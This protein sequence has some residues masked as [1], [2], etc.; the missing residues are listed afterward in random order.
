MTPGIK[1]EPRPLTPKNFLSAIWQANSYYSNYRWLVIP[2]NYL[3]IIHNEKHNINNIGVG[4]ISFDCESESRFNIVKKADY[5]DGNFLKYWPSLNNEWTH[6][7][8][9]SK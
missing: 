7:L 1:K 6:K 3:N 8:S 9:I 2:I 4:I 5:K